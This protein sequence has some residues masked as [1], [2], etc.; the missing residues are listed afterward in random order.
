M[1][2]PNGGTTIHTYG[3]NTNRRGGS[4]KM[5]KE[6]S[7]KSLKGSASDNGKPRRP[8]LTDLMNQSH[9]LQPHDALVGLREVAAALRRGVKLLAGGRPDS[10]Q[11]AITFAQRSRKR[12]EVNLAF[13]L[14]VWALNIHICDRN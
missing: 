14:A 11:R 1:E 9:P 8:L 3:N 13:A 5:G 2:L 7:G 10:G 12:L 6:D 4:Q